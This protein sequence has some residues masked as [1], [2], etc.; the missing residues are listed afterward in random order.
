MER[1]RV[2]LG[3]RI[4]FDHDTGSL[5]EDQSRLARTDLLLGLDQ[6]RFAVADRHRYANTGR[7]DRQRRIV[8]DLAGFVHDLHLFLVVAAGVR[9]PAA[10]NDVVGKQ[11]RARGNRWSLAGSDRFRLVLALAYQAATGT[12]SVL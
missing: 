9:L 1:G 10:W 8:E 6:D 11:V 7:G 12:G 2:D 5:A 4:V 3:V